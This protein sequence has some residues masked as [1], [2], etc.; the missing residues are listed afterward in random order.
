MTLWQVVASVVV[1]F[2]LVVLGFWWFVI[3]FDTEEET[4]YEDKK[5]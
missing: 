2:P 1:G 4:L 3:K 5:T